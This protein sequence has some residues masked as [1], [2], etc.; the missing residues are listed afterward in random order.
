MRISKLKYLFSGLLLLLLVQFGNF[1]PG[2]SFTSKR[3]ALLD[4]FNL[5]RDSHILPDLDLPRQNL[6]R[7]EL[8][9]VPQ[10]VPHLILMQNY[11]MIAAKLM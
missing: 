2:S 5:S 3:Y 6:Y 10:E 11:V 1:L 4:R 9:D 7:V 8:V